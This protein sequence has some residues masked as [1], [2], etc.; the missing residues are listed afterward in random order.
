MELELPKV[1]LISSRR[2]KLTAA[3]FANTLY[4]ARNYPFRQLTAYRLGCV[5]LLPCFAVGLGSDQ[6]QF[7][8]QE[9]QPGQNSIR[10]S[11]SRW[12]KVVRTPDNVWLATGSRP[13]PNRKYTQPYCM[14]DVNLS[15][16]PITAASTSLAIQMVRLSSFG[17]CG[18]LLSAQLAFASPEP[19]V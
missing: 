3:L 1:V 18:F 8:N 13:A 10:Y 2:L 7:K 19:V 15:I 9:V 16:I 12:S 14:R 4:Q 11:G 5:Y 6:G 17:L